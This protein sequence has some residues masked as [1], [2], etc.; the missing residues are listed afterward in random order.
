M[1]IEKMVWAHFLKPP[2]INPPFDNTRTYTR[3]GV[4]VH[5]GLGEDDTRHSALFGGAE[6]FQS[7]KEVKSAR[8]PSAQG[9]HFKTKYV[10]QMPHKPTQGQ[11][12][13]T[14]EKVDVVWS[15]VVWT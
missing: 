5:A 13:S 6:Q 15:W 10:E 4:R 11:P 12:P 3:R 14:A 2:L 8:P 1:K 7:S 9:P